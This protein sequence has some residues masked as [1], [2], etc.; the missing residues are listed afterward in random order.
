M[1]DSLIS[2][3]RQLVSCLVSE[4]RLAPF[5][6]SKALVCWCGVGRSLLNYA[7]PTAYSTLITNTLET[8]KLT[9][10]W[11]EE[12][13]NEQDKGGVDICGNVAHFGKASK[14]V[15]QFDGRIWDGVTL[16]A[17]LCRQIVEKTVTR[18]T[19]NALTNFWIVL[20]E[21]RVTDK[22]GPTAKCGHCQAGSPFT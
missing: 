7:M 19:S 20:F 6:D 11:R 17:I 12:D 5:R 1:K 9:S 14:V 15:L 21:I 8:N 22:V 10:A 16:I 18:Q 13:S 4:Q 3:H 2:L